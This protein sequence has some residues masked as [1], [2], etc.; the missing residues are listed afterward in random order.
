MGEEGQGEGVDGVG[1]RGGK[2][3]LFD[4]KFN[5]KC[6]LMIPFKAI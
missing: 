1:D 4:R 5:R 6:P 2:L 3:L